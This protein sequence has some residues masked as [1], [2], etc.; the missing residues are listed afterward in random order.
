MQG[1]RFRTVILPV[2]LPIFLGAVVFQFQSVANRVFLGQVDA[3]WLAVIANV[4]FPIWTMMAMLNSLSSG[5]TILISHALG[6]GDKERAK[7][8]GALAIVGN[9]VV[10]FLCFLFWATSSRLVYQ[11]MGVEGKILEECVAYTSIAS[12]SFL[13]A[14]VSGALTSMFQAGTQTKPLMI[15]GAVRSLLN[16]VLDAVLIFGLLGFPA[17]GLLGAATAT[18][19]AD[20][21]GLGVLVLIF[22]RKPDL[23]ARPTLA[24][25][26]AL[27]PR[28]YGSIVRMGLP[29][30]LED[31]LWNA[32]NLVLIAF[33]N[34]L[35]PL[36]TAVYSI[37]F[38]IE[39][40]AIIAFV[41][42]SQATM[43][44]VGRAKGAGEFSR[45][46]GLALTSQAAAWV[47]S[48]VLALLY[49]LIPNLL[50]G[51]FTSD[52]AMI[53]RTSPIL[54]VSTLM[55]FPKAMNFM[56][57]AGIRGLGDTKWMLGTQI[58][59][60]VFLVALGYLLIFVFHWGV[61]GLFI[62]MCID[63]G[64]RAIVNGLHF[65]RISRVRVSDEAEA[66]AA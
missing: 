1:V 57:G 34:A 16:V 62:A 22:L 2:A 29:T 42:L 8:L 7:T 65:R 6:A 63:E 35:D 11:A 43:S 64:V 15:S 44:L 32:G 60:T 13:G 3:G 17:M 5:A 39:M 9:S 27:V 31:L 54:L 50:V 19:L 4:L 45:I 52:T 24:T 10:A 40:L 25:W 41:S 58:F 36:A 53:A 56:Q 38:T 18:V 12:I 49:L 37:V 46:R 51:I 26:K 20:L 33:M 47:V 14:G 61:T 23:E 55:L 30:S 59:G 28:Q 21:V 48:G 66:S